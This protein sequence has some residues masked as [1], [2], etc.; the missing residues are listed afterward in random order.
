MS[1]NLIGSAA[2]PKDAISSEE[3][4]YLWSGNT[5]IYKHCS[6]AYLRVFISGKKCLNDWTSECFLV[7]A[8]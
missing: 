6:V 8:R 7:A 5:Y 4:G 3:V 1:I 2:F